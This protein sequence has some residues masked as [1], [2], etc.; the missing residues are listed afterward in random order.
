[1]PHREGVAIQEEEE[2]VRYDALSWVT[3]TEDMN[4]TMRMIGQSTRK[5]LTTM[6]GT[7]KSLTTIL[8]YR[9]R[10]RPPL[11]LLTG[12]LALA[13]LASMVG[14]TGS[15]YAAHTTSAAS[16]TTPCATTPLGAATPFNVFVTG[17]ASLQGSDSEGALAVGGN[18]T[19]RDYSVGATLPT[20]N[21]TRNV[22]VV[23][24]NLTFTNGAVQN[25]NAVY[26]GKGTLTNVT[27]PQGGSA[28]QG[29][30]L[31]FGAATTQLRGL[32]TYYATL[33]TNGTTSVQNS[34][35]T[36]SGSSTTLNVFTVSGSAVAGA[37]SVTINAP[38]S[39]TVLVNIDG[40][41]G[42][43]TNANFTLTGVDASHVLYNFYQATALTLQNVAIQG[44]IL[45]PSA[46]IDF[47]AGVITGTL[48][49]ASLNSGGQANSGQANSGQS[50]TGPFTGCLPTPS[51]SESGSGSGP[52]PQQCKP[53]H[54]YG[55]K[56]HCHSGPPGH[57]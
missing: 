2:V 15:A 48:V 50:N 36:L 46:A 51:Q 33:T 16:D 55:D 11:I 17:D 20:S 52:T 23:G 10:R 34:A 57:Q 40:T 12:A 38:A 43:F 7:R 39:S 21:G 44:S 35:L 45:A 8:G 3:P 25:G 4:W 32:S 29:S 41:T 49:G 19:L 6:L 28:Q 14:V 13:P 47:T 24:G 42:G 1:M 18:A 37:R 31:D 22:L 27:F 26:G 56:N 30:V 54:G 9:E 5:S 53:G